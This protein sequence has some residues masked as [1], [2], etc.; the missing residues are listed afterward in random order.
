[1]G[2]LGLL[3]NWPLL[4]VLTRYCCVLKCRCSL[5]HCQ[6]QLQLSSA[7]SSVTYLQSLEPPRP[8]LDKALEPQALLSFKKRQNEK[9]DEGLEN[10]PVSFS[11]GSCTDKNL[12]SETLSAQELLFSHYRHQ[13][14]M[15][16]SFN[17]R[18]E[19]L[20]SLGLSCELNVQ[21]IQGMVILIM[22]NYNLTPLP[23]H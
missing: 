14:E 2:P 12:A 15:F 20:I 18:K 7:N 6:P 17:S 11:R 23:W 8:C 4:P 3:R 21:R 10:L 16:A 19:F 9:V 5:L 1:M 13:L 22:P